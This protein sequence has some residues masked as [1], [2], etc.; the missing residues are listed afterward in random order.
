MLL[1]NALD[2]SLT[3]D[4]ASE[5]A[6]KESTWADTALAV[7]NENGFILIADEVMTRAQVAKLLYQVRE[8]AQNAPGIAVFRAQE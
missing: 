7:M 3:E 8:E 4:V 1:Q 2:L 6:G 5:V